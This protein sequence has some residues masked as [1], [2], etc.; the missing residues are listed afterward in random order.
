MAWGF[1]VSAESFMHYRQIFPI[2]LFTLVYL[3]N[4]AVVGYFLIPA[5][6]EVYFNARLRWW[7]SHPRYEVDASATLRVDGKEIQGKIRNISVGGIFLE[8]NQSL[9]VPKDVEV[10]FDVHRYSFDLSGKLLYINPQMSQGYGVQFTDLKFSQK[11][12]LKR[13]VKELDKAG[14]RRRPEVQDWKENFQAW[15]KQAFTSGKG[16]VPEIPENLRRKKG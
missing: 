10:K 3:V 8:A 1:W 15:A 11:R 12:D 9:E 2:F 14:V 4:L 7:E 6:R 13:M 5:V 16:I